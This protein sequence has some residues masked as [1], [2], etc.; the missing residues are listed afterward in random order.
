LVHVHLASALAVAWAPAVALG[1]GPGSQPAAV[2]SGEGAVAAQ[3]ASQSVTGEKPLGFE[4]EELQGGSVAAGVSE[5]WAMMVKALV[6]LAAV[7]VLAYL[8]LAKGLGKLAARQSL[9]KAIQIVDRVGLDP[10]RTL[11]LVDVEGVRALVAAGEH[12]MSITVLPRP[13][14][15]ADFASVLREKARPQAPAAGDEP[16][17]PPGVGATRPEDKGSVG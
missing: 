10:R 9:G 5:A 6:A 1:Q 2:A 15:P 4:P 12:A 7:V 14:G 8:V 13:G 3:P 11:Y 16:A 17:N